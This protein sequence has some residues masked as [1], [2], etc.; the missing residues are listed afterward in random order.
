MRDIFTDIFAQQQPPNPMEAA[1]RAMRPQLRQRF[2]ARS[3]VGELQDGY[4]VLLDRRPVRTPA[5]RP[6]VAPVRALAQALADEW[7]AQ[8]DTIDPTKMPLTRLA[9]TII[10]GVSTRAEAVSADIA[11]Y[12]SADMIL[13]RAESPATLRAR[14]AQHWNPV[15]DWA[16]TALNA[17]FILTEGVMHTTQPEATIAAVCAAIPQ[18]SWRLGALHAATTLTGSA[19]IAL[20]LWRGAMSL[21][22]AWMAAH[23]DEDFQMEQWGRDQIALE[24]R[25]F[26]FAEM[27]A[28][29]LVL[30]LLG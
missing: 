14:Q 23:V 16:R 22:Q 15:L 27:Q 5:R 3:Q 9:N 20:A 29:A 18:D 28:A 26:H 24:R 2:Y 17:R 8:R 25:A 11:K 30:E 4:T 10:D 21:E 13:Y 19:L 1:R 7:E 6:L 12:L